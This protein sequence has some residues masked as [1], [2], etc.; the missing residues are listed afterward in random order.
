MPFVVSILTELMIPTNYASNKP[1][2]AIAVRSPRFEY[3]TTLSQL[4]G[5][6][7]ENWYSLFPDRLMRL[8]VITTM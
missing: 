5:F 7:K 1:S 6:G 2:T 3:H 4:V 8:L